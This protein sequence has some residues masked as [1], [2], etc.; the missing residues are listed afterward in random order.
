M[1]PSLAARRLFDTA[2]REVYIKL[3]K[4]KFKK[5]PLSKLSDDVALPRDPST[6]LTAVSG[7]H[8]GIKASRILWI[9]IKP[10]LLYNDGFAFAKPFSFIRHAGPYRSV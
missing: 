9:K 3:N 7:K 8:S 2:H 10:T 4:I 6:A 1:P 5:P